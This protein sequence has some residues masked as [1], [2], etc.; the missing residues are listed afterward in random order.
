MMKNAFNFVALDLLDRLLAFNP[1]KRISVEEALAHPY[2]APYYDP[3][4]EVSISVSLVD[5]TLRG[6]YR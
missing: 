5:D 3:S 1:S 4:D 6:R 2:L